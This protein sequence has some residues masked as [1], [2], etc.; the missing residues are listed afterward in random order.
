[1]DVL[2]H[3][4]GKRRPPLSQTA[5]IGGGVEERDVGAKS[6]ELNQ[7]GL[8]RSSSNTVLLNRVRGESA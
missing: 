1:M 6:L 5:A 4:R 7:L 8:P 3:A 2:V